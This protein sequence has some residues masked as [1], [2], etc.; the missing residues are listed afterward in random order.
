MLHHWNHF[1]S[2]GYYL[3]DVW[4]ADWKLLKLCWWLHL[5][6]NRNCFSH[7]LD[8]RT[9]KRLNQSWTPLESNWKMKRLW[10]Q[11]FTSF[12]NS[13]VSPYTSPAKAIFTW[14]TSAWALIPSSKCKNIVI[15]KFP[16]S[17][18]GQGNAR[19]CH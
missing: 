2:S 12:W 4:G 7:F 6:P 17:L 5:L 19:S 15:W 11:Y 9:T 16:L 8:L 1:F 3:V 13:G 14:T 18:W 10:L